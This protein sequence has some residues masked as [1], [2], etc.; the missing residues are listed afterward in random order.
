ME[1]RLTLCKICLSITISVTLHAAIFLSDYFAVSE[2]GRVKALW[3]NLLRGTGTPHHV[4]R[5]LASVFQSTGGGGG[6][7]PGRWHLQDA[8]EGARHALLAG[9]A[10]R[11][12][13]KAD[14]RIKCSRSSP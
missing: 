2:P 6:D 5:A 12:F 14:P 10:Q 3:G 13:E 7:F 1:A 8:V 9:V 4:R 11:A